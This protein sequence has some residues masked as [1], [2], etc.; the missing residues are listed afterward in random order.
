MEPY[1][2]NNINPSQLKNFVRE[3]CII[4]S[5][6][7]KKQKAVEDL[8]R[9]L[10][11]IKKPKGIKL[12]KEHIAKLMPKINKVVE[13]EKMLLTKHSEEA[14][15]KQFREQIKRLENDLYQARKERDK[16]KDEN[17]HKIDQ[18][19]TTVI[20]IKERISNIIRAKMQK[21]KRINELN[22]KIDNQF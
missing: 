2:L 7:A 4:S 8:D 19:A 20:S 3:L 6:Y 17:K 10:E 5:R 15:E 18:L 16:A 14:K 9:H 11:K 12:Q 1:P 21:E 13:A 22:Q